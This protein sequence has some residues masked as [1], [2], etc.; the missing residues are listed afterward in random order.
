MTRLYKPGE[1]APEDG[2]YIKVDDMGKEINNAFE[3]SKGDKFPPTQG[4]NVNYKMI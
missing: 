4:E 3:M 2:M 1:L